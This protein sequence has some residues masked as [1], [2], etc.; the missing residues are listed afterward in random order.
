MLTSVFHFSGFFL[1]RRIKA[2]RNVYILKQQSSLHLF[3]IIQNLLLANVADLL[4]C[5]RL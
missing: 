4:L 2:Y 3:N 1:V 5:D